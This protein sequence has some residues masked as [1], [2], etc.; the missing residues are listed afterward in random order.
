M[1]NFLLT[2]LVSFILWLLLTGSLDQQELVAGLIVSLVAAALSAGRITIFSDIRLS[3]AAPLAFVMYLATFLLALLKANLD[4]AR[5][6][7][8]PSLP[9]NPAMIEF[10]TDLQSNLAKLV[11]ANSITLTPGTLAVDV[12]ENKILVHWIDCPEGISPRQ[13]TEQIAADFEKHIRGFLL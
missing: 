7:L 12:T 3:P 1:K 13:A 11:L 6:V 8:S 9:L 10:T 2:T 4:M 5:R